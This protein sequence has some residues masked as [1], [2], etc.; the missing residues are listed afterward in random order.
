MEVA[1]LVLEH[2]FGLARVLPTIGTVDEDM[3]LE[4]PARVLVGWQ[5]AKDRFCVLTSE[6]VFGDPVTRKAL[7]ITVIAVTKSIACV[8]DRG[9]VVTQRV[10]VE[11]HRLRVHPPVTHVDTA[12]TVQDAVQCDR[13]L[14]EGGAR[15]ERGRQADDGAIAIDATTG[16]EIWE[17][18]RDYPKDLAEKV[19]SPQLSRSKAMAR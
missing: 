19:R 16:D 13:V 1:I 3:V 8:P 12:E 18:K 2:A 17:Y 15:V 10:S 7:A 5:K 4:L 11:W 9:P 14:V 6:P